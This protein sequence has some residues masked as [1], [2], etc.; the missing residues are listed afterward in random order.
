[1]ALYDLNTAK[2][3]VTDYA[4]KK[5]G[6]GPQNDDE[7]G[8]IG[9]GIDLNNIDDNALN[10]AFSNADALAKRLGASGPLPPSPTPPGGIGTANP[11]GFT[12]PTTA[13]GHYPGGGIGT[14][15]PGGLTGPSTIPSGGGITRADGFNWRDFNSGTQAPGSGGPQGGGG[16]G[17]VPPSGGV[18]NGA[19]GGGGGTGT[20]GGP[21]I[22]PSLRDLIPGLFEPRQPSPWEL[23][24]QQALQQI[25]TRGAQT[26]SL[27]D[28][29]LQPVADAYRSRSQ[30]GAESLRAAAAER[31]AQTGTP[32]ND[33]QALMYQQAA[34]TDVAGFE[35]NL[36]Q[37]E[38]QTR[39]DELMQAIQIANQMGQFDQAQTLQQQLALLEATMQQQG[40]TLQRELGMGDLD[41]RREL[42]FGDLGL[43]RELGFADINL[44]GQGLDLQR[45]L[46]M[47]DLGLRG[48]GLDLQGQLGRGALGMELL[49]ALL[50]N[51]QFYSSLGLDAAELQALLNQSAIRDLFGGLS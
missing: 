20:G 38:M 19:T 14:S 15:N 31:A 50:Q 45:E 51:D 21:N 32:F 37:T 26:P 7:W 30:R 24:A 22:P 8:E 11:G 18:G 34:N 9:Q 17:S 44:R 4:T 36:L 1:M 35:A 16:D 6:R 28:P 3:R 39:R 23:Q 46:G 29:N 25:I 33:P 47:G 5:Y 43:R 10:R 41:L 48:R 42:G 40:L 49:R 12:G 2:S 13:P 27:T